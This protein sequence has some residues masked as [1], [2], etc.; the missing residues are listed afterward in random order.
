M[1]RVLLF[2]AF[3]NDRVPPMLDEF[4]SEI[5]SA[6][7]RIG[8]SID[9]LPWAMEVVVYDYLRDR[10]MEANSTSNQI[11]IDTIVKM[12][13]DN[14]EEVKEMAIH[15][16]VEAGMGE[17]SIEQTYDVGYRV[18]K[19]KNYN[20]IARPSTEKR[21]IQK[22]LTDNTSDGAEELAQPNETATDKAFRTARNKGR[23]IMRK[24]L[25][26]KPIEPPRVENH[27]HNTIHPKSITTTPIQQTPNVV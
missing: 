3:T 8:P 11:D 5:S 23:N 18:V 24:Y 7:M 26:P 21:G 13:E 9:K 16:L 6:K 14:Q 27:V 22:A 25:A 1:S 15:K 4:E 2:E 17:D 12:L 20:L 10:S 19:L